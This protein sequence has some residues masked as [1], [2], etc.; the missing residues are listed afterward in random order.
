MISSI[1]TLGEAGGAALSGNI[2]GAVQ[3]GMEFLNTWKGIGNSVINA[4]NTNQALQQQS[5]GMNGQ[6]AA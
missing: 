5:F 4:K 3:K 2:G 6:P 1:G